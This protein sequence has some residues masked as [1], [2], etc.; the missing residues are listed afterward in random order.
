MELIDTHCHLNDKR[1]AADLAATI[2]RA[3]AQG[4]REMIVIGV[5]QVTGEQALTLAEKYDN[6][7]AACA[8]HPVDVIDCTAADKRWLE[9]AWDHPKVVAIGETGLD[10]HW[11]KSPHDVQASYFRWHLEQ[12]IERKLPFIVHDRD[13]HADTLAILREFYNKYGPLK[14]VMHSYAGGAGMLE[15]FLKLGLYI[16]VSGVVTFKNA[17]NIKETVPRIP[18]N[19]LL[20]ET[21]APYLT[22]VPFRGKRNEPAYT[23]Y[24]AEAIAELRGESLAHIANITSA[25]ARELFNLKR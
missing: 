22:P 16:S 5:D 6:I 9:A 17:Q 11:D 24:T 25:N 18:A 12:S 7:Y 10:Y 2:E 20:V 14:G 8:W 23:Y 13:A 21:D 4:V 1:F 19:R 3:V 15:E